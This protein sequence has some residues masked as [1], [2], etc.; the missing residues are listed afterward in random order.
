MT[1]AI[2][3]RDARFDEGRHISFPA[4]HGR[5]TINYRNFTPIKGSFRQTTRH[6][7]RD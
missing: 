1:D 5:T 7:L 2:V 4:I 6:D 3:V